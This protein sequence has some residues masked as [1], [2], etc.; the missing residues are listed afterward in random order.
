MMLKTIII[1]FS[2]VDYYSCVCE[3]KQVT[4][5]S[6]KRR[7]RNVRGRKGKEGMGE[8][9]SK[10]RGRGDNKMKGKT[11]EQ[12]TSRESMYEVV[13]QVNFSPSREVSECITGHVKVI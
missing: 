2:T 9:G 7:G 12:T 3:R 4:G 6:R 1:F 13:Y 10:G 8:E 11:V 5:E